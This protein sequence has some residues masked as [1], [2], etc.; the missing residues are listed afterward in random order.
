MRWR[1]TTQKLGNYMRRIAESHPW[2]VRALGWLLGLATALMMLGVFVAFVSYSS[3]W[4]APSNMMAILRAVVDVNG[5]LL[6]LSGIM[7]GN[8]LLTVSQQISQG[9]VQL[10]QRI[11][12]FVPLDGL[13]KYRRIMLN[14][15]LTTSLLFMG[16]IALSLGMMTYVPEA[17]WPLRW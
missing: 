13:A 14:A 8:T 11:P 3:R 7:F 5:V 15:W 10:Q 16:S 1:D 6:G 12:A 9:R 17:P 2:L 4:T